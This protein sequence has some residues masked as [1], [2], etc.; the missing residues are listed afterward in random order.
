[1]TKIEKEAFDDMV[2]SI[3]YDSRKK[4]VKLSPHSSSKY[5]MVCL[6]DVMQSIQDFKDISELHKTP[7]R[8]KK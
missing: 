7:K 6:S 5:T 2:K 1:M 4:L 3:T 8:S